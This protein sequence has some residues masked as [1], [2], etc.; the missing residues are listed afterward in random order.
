[1][2]RFVFR[3]ERLLIWRRLEKEQQEG[4]LQALFHE[5]QQQDAVRIALET[6]ARMAE[7][8]VLRQDVFIEERQ[9]LGNY[10]RFLTNERLR[11]G[12]LRTEL[13]GRIEA[14][15]LLLVEAE[16]KLEALRNMREDKQ[17]AWRCQMEKEQGDLVDELVVARW[18]RNP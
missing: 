13:E 12:R 17:A 3:L 14:Q 16:R 11:L 10:R 18:R 8:S 5:R 1:L 6:G 2:K 9:A 7:E 4:R 15:R